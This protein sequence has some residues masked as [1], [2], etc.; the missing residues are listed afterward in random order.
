M[1]IIKSIIKAIGGIILATKD[2]VK[3]HCG[4]SRCTY[5]VYTKEKVDELLNG[6]ASSNNVYVKNDFAVLEGIV[7][8]KAGSVGY[9][10]TLPYPEGFTQENTVVISRILGDTEPEPEDHYLSTNQLNIEINNDDLEFIQQNG[11]L[12]KSVEE[13][14]MVWLNPND[15]DISVGDNRTT[16]EY[17]CDWKYKVVLMKY[18][19]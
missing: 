4:T 13:Q 14:I 3:G 18:K 5:D 10:K 15:L 1:K 11:R 16:N 6:K 8:V 2:T 12:R 7:T 17:D 9:T 19:D